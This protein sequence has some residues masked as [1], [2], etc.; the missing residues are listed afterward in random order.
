MEARFA[1]REAEE[2]LKLTKLAKEQADDTAKQGKTIMVFTIV[3]IIF[4]S[5][6]P[7]SKAREFDC[8]SYPCRL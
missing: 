8:Q 5:L 6:L 4:V 3:T 1:R 7:L 2:S